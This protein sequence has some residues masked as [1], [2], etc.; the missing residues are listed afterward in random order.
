MPLVTIKLARRDNPITR[1]QKV[2]LIAG[3]TQLLQGTLAKRRDDVVVLIE[4]ID[5]DNWGQGGQTATTLR[6]HA[7]RSNS[8]NNVHALRVD[9]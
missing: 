5:P 1:E 7:K 4:E 8:R 6:Q 3:V 2:A 9:T